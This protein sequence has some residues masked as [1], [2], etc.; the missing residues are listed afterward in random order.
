MAPSIGE[1][2]AR[3]RIGSQELA[4]LAGVARATV[5]DIAQNRQRPQRSTAKAIEGALTGE[6][7]ILRDYLIAM[8]GVPNGE[9]R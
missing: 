3:L 2:M 7:I 6:E 4:K 8:H 1:R 5:N 9:G